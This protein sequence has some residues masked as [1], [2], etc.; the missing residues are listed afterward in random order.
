VARG[1]WDRF[2]IEQVLV[3]L[4]TNALK[5]GAGKP[6][7]VQVSTLDRRAFVAVTDQGIG[8]SPQDQ[9]RVFGR[10]ERAVSPNS[11]SGLGLGLY[12]SK[13]IVE[14]H[15]GMISLQS[16]VGK[17]STFTLELPTKEAQNIGLRT[18]LVM[19]RNDVPS[20]PAGTLG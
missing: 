8:I 19:G 3:N 5:Y 14:A 12:I 9:S 6:I 17:G 10:F 15:Q 7:D 16:E 2:R 11:I 1:C 20:N 13:K 4:L 18:E